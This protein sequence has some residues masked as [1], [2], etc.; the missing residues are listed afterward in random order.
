MDETKLKQRIEGRQS[1]QELLAEYLDG[2]T[3]AWQQGFLIACRRIANE[4]LGVEQSTPARVAIEE[5][6]DDDLAA[7]R[8]VY[9]SDYRFSEW[10][11]EFM[12]SVLGQS[13]P[14]TDKQRAVVDRIVSKYERGC[15]G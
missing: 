7:L 10:E 1:A 14:L 6:S 11:I 12:E 2:E 8:T 5:D 9:A 13:F 3:E 4:K 15:D